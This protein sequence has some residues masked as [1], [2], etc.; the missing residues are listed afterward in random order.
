MGS[1]AGIGVARRGFAAFGDRFGADGERLVPR[2]ADAPVFAARF[3]TDDRDFA[4]A[5]FGDLVRFV[6]LAF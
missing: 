3:D 4:R 5:A 1:D 2:A 6:D